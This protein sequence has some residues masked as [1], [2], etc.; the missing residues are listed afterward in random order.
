M[1]IGLSVMFQRLKAGYTDQELYS[2]DL[3]FA[4][5]AETRGF[6]SVWTAEHHFS[7]YVMSP[8]PAQFLT[9]VA[10][11]T[12]H[13]RLGS[14]VMVLP[15][16]HP[17]RM[18]EQVS[19]LDTL[20]GG[21]VLLGVGRGLGPV[22]F[23]GFGVDMGSSRQMF[24][25]SADALINAFDTGVLEY[26]GA[27]YKQPPVTIRPAPIAPLRGRVYAS[28]VSPESMRLIAQLGFGIMII[29]QKPWK[30]IVSEIAEYAEMFI[31]LNGMPPPRPLLVNFTLVHEDAERAQ[32]LQ[33]TY[34][35]AYS[36][37]AVEH[38]EFANQRLAT[39]PGYEYY[40]R[41]KEKLDTHGVEAYARFLAG[42][43]ISG[44]PEV[45]TEN[46]IERVR[47]LDGAGVINIFNFGGMPIKD[48]RH[49][50]DLFTEQVLPKLK[51]ADPFRDAGPRGYIDG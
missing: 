30:T 8:N 34:G 7:D 27:V 3:A 50:F 35:L 10:A 16:H 13:V 47:M 44:T 40:T 14:M 49:S 20:S 4:D 25:E 17:A 11:R 18:A 23:D 51:A 36:A 12:S 29:A 41:L 37:S 9:W 19:V 15:W 39:I 2:E 22:E 48:A 32:E 33:E 46:L 43:Q 38:Y 24:V 28:S 42:L 26:D 21:R 6:D 1:H 31:E 5:L 45:V